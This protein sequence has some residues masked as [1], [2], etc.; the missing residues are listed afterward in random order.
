MTDGGVYRKD[1]EE[2]RDFLR[3]ELENG[4]RF[5]SFEAGKQGLTKEDFT[6]FKTSFEALEH[7]YENTTDRDTY[8]VK[9]I[10][11]VEKAITG[12][13]NNKEKLWLVNMQKEISQLL[14][15]V[16]RMQQKTFPENS[17]EVQLH[18]RQLSR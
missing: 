12:L 11:A 3:N 7:A 5:V 8:T 15:I 10:S 1:A 6:T 16:E 18:D 2:I 13:L 17:K 9:S 4:N 14:N